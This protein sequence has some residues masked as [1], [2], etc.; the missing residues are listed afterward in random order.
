[1][2]FFSRGHGS[3]RKFIAARLA[4]IKIYEKRRELKTGDDYLKEKS[5]FSY[6]FIFQPTVHVGS[7]IQISLVP[8]SFVSSLLHRKLRL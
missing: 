6:I 1:M 7:E 8:H 2:R 3:K 5:Y 4:K